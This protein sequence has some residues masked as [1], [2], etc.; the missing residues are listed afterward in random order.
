MPSLRYGRKGKKRGEIVRR[1]AGS[2][3]GHKGAA[4]THGVTGGEL[5][6]EVETV[7]SDELIERPGGTKKREKGGNW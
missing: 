2:S 4:R 1:N 7:N 5:E 6:T 3:L